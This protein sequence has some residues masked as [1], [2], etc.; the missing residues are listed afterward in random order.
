MN[1]GA[2][3]ER[4]GRLPATIT[5]EPNSP[6]A[7]AKVSSDPVRMAGAIAGSTTRR[8]AASGQAPR[9]KAAC[10]WSASSSISTG[11]TARTT[12]GKVTSKRATTIPGGANRMRT[13]WADSQAPTRFCGP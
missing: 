5:T 8:K 10:S 2:V 13:P 6:R 11:S 9:V 4:P 1:T 3:S 7:R 12:S